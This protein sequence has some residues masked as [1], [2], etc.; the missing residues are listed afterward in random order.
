LVK[1]FD[2]MAAIMKQMSGMGL[3]D[4]MKTVQQ[5][6]QSGM[7]NPG[8]KLGKAKQGTGKRLTAEERAKLKKQRERE[9]RRKKRDQKGKS[10]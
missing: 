10:V 7:L 6:G 9:L 1:H 5:L 8:A 4:R 2:G 3:R